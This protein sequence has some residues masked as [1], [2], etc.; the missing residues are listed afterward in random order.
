MSLTEEAIG[1]I[2]A[3]IVVGAVALPISMDA[4]VT[5]TS[6]VTNQTHN[7]T[8]TVPETITLTGIEDGVVS[9]SES[10]YAHDTDTSTASELTSG[11]NYT[12]LDYD[13]GTINITSAPDMNNT[14]DYYLVTFNYK[15][16]GYIDN[17][18]ARMIIDYIPVLIALGILLGAFAIVRY[19]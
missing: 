13:E 3:V 4:P 12:V 6:G 11:T 2:V 9:D 16:D 8:G 17:S 5:S 15:P 19:R 10:I 14:N 18:T 1:F 7:S